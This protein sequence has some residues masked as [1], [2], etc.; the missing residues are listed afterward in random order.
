M[1]SLFRAAA[2]WHR[3]IGALHLLETSMQRGVKERYA[4]VFPARNSSS[5][6]NAVGLIRTSI[7]YYSKDA[8]S[9]N[10]RG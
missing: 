9:D 4:R 7:L 10:K 2:C 6:G 8:R 3:E 5:A 1:I